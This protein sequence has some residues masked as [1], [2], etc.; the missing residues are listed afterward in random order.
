M[1]MTCDLKTAIFKC[2]ACGV[3]TWMPLGDGRPVGWTKLDF[4]RASV[5]LC[6]ECSLK[7]RDSIE[8][9]VPG[10]LR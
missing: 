7:V 8:A 5:D 6:Q 9:C 2:D 10:L 3:Q 4:D 1:A